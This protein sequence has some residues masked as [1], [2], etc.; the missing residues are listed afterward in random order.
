MG[1]S[2]SF[3][4]SSIS[5]PPSSSSSAAAR[6]I[7]SSSVASSSSSSSP[8]PTAYSSSS[9]AEGPRGAPGSSTMSANVA[10]GASPSS[11]SGPSSEGS[12]GSGPFPAA[13]SA[14]A[15]ASISRYRARSS[16]MGTSASFARSSISAPPPSSSS[17]SAAAR[18]ISSSSVASSSSSAISASPATNSSSSASSGSSP[19]FSEPPRPPPR[20]AGRS[21][22]DEGAAPDSSSSAVAFP[23]PFESSIASFASPTSASSGTPVSLVASMLEYRSVCPRRKSRCLSITVLRLA[24]TALCALKRTTFSTFIQNRITSFPMWHAVFLCAMASSL[25]RFTTRLS[26]SRS[27]FRTACAARRASFCRNLR[28]RTKSPESH[29]I[30]SSR[31]SQCV[32]FRGGSG[33]FGCGFVRGGRCSTDHARSMTASS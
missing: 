27:D 15:A 20:G 11:S 29:R 6:R 26:R 5:A 21:G 2:A 17:P 31:W 30:S 9:S 1:T 7:S 13:A 10:S 24:S 32:L 33:N 19:D 4:R 14:S 12:S 3:A 8:S 28:S 23:S 16:S 25:A 22:A 18:R